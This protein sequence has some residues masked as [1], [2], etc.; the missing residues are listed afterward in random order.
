MSGDSHLHCVDDDGGG[1][2]KVCECRRGYVISGGGSCI[3]GKPGHIRVTIL[4]IFF[5]ILSSSSKTN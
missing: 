5:Y 3:A 1:G 4:S 2:K